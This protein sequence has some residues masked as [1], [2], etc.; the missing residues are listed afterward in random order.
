MQDYG[1]HMDDASFIKMVWYF[2]RA[3][4]L[5][6]NV[7]TGILPVFWHVAISSP[8]STCLWCNMPHSLHFM[9]H[10]PCLI[11]EYRNRVFL[12]SEAFVS[13]AVLF[14]WLRRTDRSIRARSTL[15]NI[16]SLQD[17]FWKGATLNTVLSR[18]VTA[19]TF[20]TAT[21][22]SKGIKH[23][24]PAVKMDKKFFWCRLV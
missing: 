4:T 5:N 11:M 17:T 24:K 7:S 20:I 12:C 23:R 1:P 2:S 22:K 21:C 3:K 16:S 8:F 18:R 13:N 9:V 19:T 14:P 15:F 10:A 6:T